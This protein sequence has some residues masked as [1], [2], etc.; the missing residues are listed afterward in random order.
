MKPLTTLIVFALLAGPL[1]AADL[2]YT[3]PVTPAPPDP[4]SLLVRLVGLTA[5]T[6]AICGGLIWVTRRVTKPKTGPVNDRLV[7]ESSLTLNTWASVHVLKA[8]G[9]SVA[10]TTDATGIRSIV[11]LSEKFEEL[12]GEVE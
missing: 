9:Q 2:D 4:M 10:V 6:L 8:D 12:V 5:L 7:I 1:R 11:V 3:P